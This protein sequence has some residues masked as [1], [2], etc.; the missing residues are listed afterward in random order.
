M[1][2]AA[3]AGVG[4][5][6]RHGVGGGQHPADADAGEEAIGDHRRYRRGNAGQIHPDRHQHQAGDH[7]VFAAVFVSHPAQQHR[8]EAH[9][10]QFGRQ[11]HAQRG[12]RDAPVGGDARRGEGARQHVEPVERVEQHHQDHHDPLAHAHRRFIDDGDRVAPACA[13]SHCLLFPLRDVAA[14]IVDSGQH[15]HQFIDFFGR[16][17]AFQPGFVLADRELGLAE[18][19]GRLPA[20]GTAPACGRRFRSARGA[21]NRG[22]AGG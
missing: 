2:A 20:S 3:P 5:F 11:H 10:D 22:P 8:A 16:E 21:G 12:A 13:S 14:S 7:G 6:G 15:F 19:L 17:P 18:R 1:V 9:A 4:A